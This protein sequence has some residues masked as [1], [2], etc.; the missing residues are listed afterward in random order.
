MYSN[1]NAEM[2]RREITR[3]ELAKRMNKN[4]TTISMKLNGKS[5]ISLREAMEIKMVLGVDIP[6]EELF[7]TDA[8]MTA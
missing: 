3:A 8:E 1:L 2:S 5:D 4:P 7:S 6:I